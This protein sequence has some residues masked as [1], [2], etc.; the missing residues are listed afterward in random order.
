MIHFLAYFFSRLGVYEVQQLSG[1]ARHASLFTGK[2]GIY[3]CTY[4]PVFLF[5]TDLI[6]QTHLECSKSTAQ[7]GQ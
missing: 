1:G 5:Y 6:Y 2:S 7:S 3:I 4:P